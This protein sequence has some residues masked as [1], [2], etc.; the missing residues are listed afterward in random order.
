MS[1]FN[2]EDFDNTCINDFCA[3]NYEYEKTAI[4]KPPPNT[5]VKLAQRFIFIDSA[6]FTIGT[7]DNNTFTIDF[8]ET[9]NDVVEIELMS[10]QLPK[11]ADSNGTGKEV[12]N[13]PHNYILL[14]LDNLELANYKKISG[15]SAVQNCFTRLL[16]PQKTHNIFFGR[17]KNFTNTYEFRPMLQ[18]LSKLTLRFTNRTGGV[19]VDGTDKF[20]NTNLSAGGVPQT[21]HRSVQLTFAI[22]YQT[23]S[24]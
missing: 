6:D 23:Q 20:L 5:N 3:N 22:T 12:F 9:I 4:I 2:N 10:C 17:I 16:I 8:G 19:L 18:K 21:D 15:D 13:Y 1:D 11:T 24:L 7:N 14:F